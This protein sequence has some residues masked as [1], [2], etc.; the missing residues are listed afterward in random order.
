MKTWKISKS[1]IFLKSKLFSEKQR[2]NLHIANVQ[3]ANFNSFKLPN[4]CQNMRK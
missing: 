1:K 3:I 2:S 4:K